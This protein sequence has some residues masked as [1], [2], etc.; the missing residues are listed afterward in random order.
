MIQT[1]SKREAQQR[2]DRIH[3][4]REQLEELLRL[5]VFD[6]PAEQR[7][8]LDSYLH[9][10][11]AE[12]AERYDVD[13]SERQ[14][15]ISLGMRILSALGGL[16]FCAALYLFFYRIWGS[17]TTP[18]QVAILI[19]TPIL[20]LSA[21]DFISRREK[22]YYYTT[23]ISLVAIASFAINLGV[24]GS[25]FNIMPSPGIFLACGAFA[26]VLAY[27]YRLRLALAAGLVAL[28]IFA[29]ATIA[30]WTGVY[31]VTFL[32]RPESVLP[33]CLL[34]LAVPLVV[35][36]SRSADFPEAYHGIGLLLLLFCLELLIHAGH[37]SYFPFGAE[38]IESMYR[39]VGFIV[40]GLVIYW[41]I[42]KSHPGFVNLGSLF[43]ALYLFD[44]LFSWW[45]D[46]MPKYLFFLIIALIATC[47]LA[48]FRKI[49]N[50]VREQVS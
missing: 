7:S 14:K 46:W 40:A 30:T 2:V 39:I 19:A 29:A 37:T 11:L 44:Q 17:L 15:Q 27:G 31:W 6:L 35:R 47:L 5:G 25:L 20:A 49:R 41:G 45:W 38:T 9:K 28:L 34:L 12:L 18:P 33:G 48:I 4:F 21:M 32:Q 43:F 23:L 8:R 1:S 3:S 13:I 10:T 50:R 24:M 16:A 36:H 26:I 22:T 42:R